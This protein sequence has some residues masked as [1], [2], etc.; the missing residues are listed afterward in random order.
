M[1]KLLSLA[2]AAAAIAA[3]PAAAVT[4]DAF[5][6]FNGVN[7]NGNFNYGYTDGTTLTSFDFSGTNGACALGTGSTC[8][9]ATALGNLPQASIGGS[10]PTVNVPT[11]AVLVHPGNSDAQSNYVGFVATTGGSYNY[12]IDLQSRGIDTT[13]G[14]GY[15][16]FTSVGGVV[17]L[18][19]RNVIPTYLATAT[20][21]G[22][23]SLAVG[24][25]FGVIVDRNGIYYG[26]STGVKFVVDGPS[27]VPEP[28]VWGLMIAGFAMVGA[29]ARRRSAVVA[30]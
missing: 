13:D 5:A 27:A 29:A 3:A 25:V 8:L 2:I 28:A 4:Y 30:A 1:Q 16:S 23:Q 6:S 14:I 17:T 12:T 21:A 9:Y 18:G 22:T 24:S 7:G 20:L 26:D 15:R 19:A 10:Y 11:D